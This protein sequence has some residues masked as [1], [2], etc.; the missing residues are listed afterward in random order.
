VLYTQAC[1]TVKAVANINKFQGVAD[2]V[3]G[4]YRGWEVW[5]KSEGGDRGCRYD[6][7]GPIGD[8]VPKPET[9]RKKNGG[10]GRDEKKNKRRR[11]SRNRAHGVG[12]TAGCPHEATRMAKKEKGRGTGA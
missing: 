2:S 4:A 1:A 7:R 5:R 11:L 10:R 6:R 9:T 8:V 3:S 12:R